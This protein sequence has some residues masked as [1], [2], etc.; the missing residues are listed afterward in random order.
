MQFATENKFLIHKSSK[1]MNNK[2]QIID[3]C[4]LLIVKMVAA[5]GSTL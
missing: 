4:H 1:W 2:L 3:D 5:L